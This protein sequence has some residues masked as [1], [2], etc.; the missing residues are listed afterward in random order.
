MRV[1]I[2]DDEE[3]VREGIELAIDWD[4]FG[5][6]QRFQAENGLQALEVMKQH[7][8]EIVFC[9]MSMPKM[10]GIQLLD[11]L[12]GEYPDT[13][14]IV[15]SGYNDFTYTRA[16]IR[17]NG[18]DYILKP[19][20]RRDLEQAL[21]KAVALCKQR[22]DSMRMQRDTEFLVQQADYVVMEQKISQ[23]MKG[24]NTYFSEIK[25]Y[26][27]KSGIPTSHL[28]TTLILMRNDSRL[29][30]QRYNAEGG[31]FSFAIKNMAQEAFSE[32]GNY[33]LFRFDDHLWI[34]MTGEKLDYE[35]TNKLKH[36]VNHLTAAWNSTIG[37]DTLVGF[38]ERASDLHHIQQQ[39]VSARI[40]LLQSPISP[41][42]RL[43]EQ[44]PLLSSKE[45]LL[46]IALENRN[47]L[48]VEE[49]IHRFAEELRQCGDLR[50]KDL[51]LYTK[52]ANYMLERASRQMNKDLEDL[53]IPMWISDITEWGMAWI[54]QWWRLIEECGDS[55]YEGRGIQVI[56]EYIEQ[57]FH[58]KISLTGLS[59]LFH[60]SPQY[61]AKRFKEMYNTTV[62]TYQ[63]ELQM[64]KAKSLLEH[65]DMP[66]IK[67][68]EA[69]GYQDENY[70]SKVFRKQHGMPPLKYRKTL[71]DS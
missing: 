2:V 10:N 30:E 3:H 43:E 29:I 51:Q 48:Y 1:L 7:K 70:F 68:A 55:G 38:S 24:D 67:I 54:Q 31:L 4:Q 37:L 53:S 26:C 40:A 62:I 22:E 8:P 15:V 16:T 39:I 9:D 44:K 58:E 5:I 41:D 28:R 69:I 64:Q 57:H 50:L 60:F 45:M 63:T 49:I 23:L 12:R 27:E 19:F 17:A 34:L 25:K 18:V 59:E 36:Y 33:L 61:I 14:I 66:I 65:S 47:K 42:H 71:R 35:M 56:R 20:K 13:H 11:Q 6:K 32:Y 21:S 46:N 52:E